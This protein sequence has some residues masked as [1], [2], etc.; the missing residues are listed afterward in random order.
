MTRRAW[1]R[2]AGAL[3]LAAGIGASVWRLRR[4]DPDDASPLWALQRPAP[5]GTMVSMAAWRGRP[6]LLNFW[7]TWCSPCVREIPRLDRF[8]Q[9]QA[10]RGVTVL[11][12]AVDELEPVRRFL[13]RQ[14][15]RY[16]VVMVGAAGVAL[17]RELGN[18]DG[19]LPFS[20]L[21]GRNGRVLR[22]RVGEIDEPELLAW[23][24]ALD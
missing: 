9:A 18:R 2:G 23:A 15:V 11:G 7:A 8:A 20:V 6:L 10:S 4:P 3:A 22:R 24:A 12:L 21:V 13:E 17:S 19:G 14:P 16:P 5:D 1:I